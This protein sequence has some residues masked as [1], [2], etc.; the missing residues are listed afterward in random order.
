MLNPSSPGACRPTHQPQAPGITVHLAWLGFLVWLG[1]YID[2]THKLTINPLSLYKRLK[3]PRGGGGIQ[4]IPSFL[5]R[6]KDQP[7]TLLQ[8]FIY[9]N[10]DTIY[11]YFVLS[12]HKIYALKKK[13]VTKISPP[14]DFLKNPMGGDLKNPSTLHPI[15]MIFFVV[16]GIP[17]QVPT[18]QVYGGHTCVVRFVINIY[19]V[20]YCN[21]C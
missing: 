7:I 15:F 8:H 1:L 4:K 18:F 11:I 21:K 10:L 9:Y 6:R 5:H 16:P 12:D 20:Y 19:Y 2:F 13:I 3:E 14:P 17:F